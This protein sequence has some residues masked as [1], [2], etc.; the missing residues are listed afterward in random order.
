MLKGE[1]PAHRDFGFKQLGVGGI[2]TIFE[3]G[4]TM[5][6]FVSH[7]E[8]LSGLCGSSGP[9][10]HS[11][12]RLEMVGITLSALLVLWS[13]ETIEEG[14][15]I[16]PFHYIFQLLSR[17][18]LVKNCCHQHDAWNGTS[19]CSAECASWEGGFLRAKTFSGF[20]SETFSN[21]PR[22]STGDRDAP[23]VKSSVA[24]R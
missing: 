2:A 22:R 10:L 4:R 7:I 1:A 3:S 12:R 13:L 8:W 23:S 18:D 24:V 20:F 21:R 16:A 17:I 11:S 14:N 19:R 15:C 9:R 6:T 5:P